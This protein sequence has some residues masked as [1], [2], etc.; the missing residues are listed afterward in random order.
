MVGGVVVRE[1]V[2]LPGSDALALADALDKP[3]AHEAA[4]VEEESPQM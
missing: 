3:A 4:M 1:A 2:S